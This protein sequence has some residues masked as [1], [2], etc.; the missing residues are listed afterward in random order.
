VID[1]PELLGR[2]PINSVTIWRKMRDGTFPR[3][4]SLGRKMGWLES[5]IDAWLLSRPT[6]KLKGDNPTP[7]NAPHWH[8]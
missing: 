6:T 3:A 2:I 5:E 4:R 7:S 8:D 1:L